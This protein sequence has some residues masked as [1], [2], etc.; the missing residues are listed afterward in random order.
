MCYY[1][2]G[3]GYWDSEEAPLSKQDRKAL[4]EEKKAILEA[5]LATINHWIETADEQSTEEK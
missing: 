5:K 1:H 4:L 3:S 2:A